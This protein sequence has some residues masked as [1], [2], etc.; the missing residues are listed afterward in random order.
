MGLGSVRWGKKWDVGGGLL[1]PT[2]HFT[3]PNPP[4][5]SSPHL[6][7]H[8]MTLTSRS[9]FTLIELIV[10][11]AVFA[12]VGA[13]VGVTL[14]NGVR[15][16]HRI[17]HVSER[18]QRARFALALIER[19]AAHALL[20]TGANDRAAPP[21]FNDTTLQFITVR[22]PQATHLPQLERVLIRAEAQPDGTTALVR[23]AAPYPAPP[24][25]PL[26]RMQTLLPQIADCRFAYLYYNP[27]NKQFMWRPAWDATAQPSAALPRGVRVSIRSTTDPPVELS[28]AVEIPTGLP[29]FTEAAQ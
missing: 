27:T 11:L 18:Q 28:D 25:G 17:H 16:F 19:D 3:R 12:I 22:Y 9:A 6:S 4:L 1:F 8:G 24:D 5:T 20:L 29:G 21:V 14:S 10:A 15:A 2:S 23:R 26:G 13:A 7:P